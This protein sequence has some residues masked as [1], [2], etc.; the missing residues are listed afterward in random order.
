[1]NESIVAELDLG[2][3]DY[4]EKLS[5]LKEDFWGDLKRETKESLRKLMETRMEYQVNDL[6]GS[7]RWQ[8]N[9]D[10]PTYRNGYYIRNLLSTYGYI[11][12]IKVP[13]LREGRIN[14]NIFKKYQRR[15]GDIDGLILEMFL[16][17][18][19]T[20]RVE[21][22][23]RPL[24]D[25]GSVS[26]GLVS[27]VTKVLNGQVKKYHYRNLRDYYKYLVLDGIYISTK[28]PVYK[29]KRCILVAYGMWI[30]DGKLR[31]EL[32]DFHMAPKGES[33]NAW[34]R[35]LGN[36]YH[37]GLEGGDLE[38]AVIDG[39]KGLRKALDLIYPQAKVQRCWA[40]K[41]RNVSNKLP[42]RMQDEM[43][44]GSPANIQ[45]RRRERSNQNIQ[46]VV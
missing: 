30:E 26:A 41:L 32:I 1:M 14:T 36:L 21:E 45:S 35:F 8:H 6:I 5:G 7:E 16:A 4:G 17:G 38:L 37:R 27:K 22:V 42:R 44:I 24:L 31:K 25:K 23:L 46:E 11:E 15:T 12:N 39:N 28:S 10:R 43:H 9:N 40:H 3:K 34:S 33:M 20:R 18:V 29:R 2:I 19:S 13:R